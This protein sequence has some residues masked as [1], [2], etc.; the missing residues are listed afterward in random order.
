MINRLRW[1]KFHG[2]NF[3]GDGGTGG[4]GAAGGSGSGSAGGTP[5]P[6]GATG[7]AGAGTGGSGAAPSGGA[8]PQ[9]DW[10]TAPQ[11]LRDAFNTTKRTLEELQAKYQP[12]DK[13][14]VRPEDV[15]N[16]QGGYQ[17][18]YSEIKGI[19]DSLGISEQEVADAIR[20]HGLVRVLDHLR[21]EAYDADQV[22]NGNQ[23]AINDR[24]LQDRIESMVEQRLSPIQQRE[25]MRLVH[26]ANS[27]T[28]RTIHDL[29]VSNFKALGMDYAQAPAALRD[30]ITTGVT[31]V[32][33]YDDDALVALKMEG[34]TA[35]IQKAFQTFQSM[36]D[37][38][39][40]ARRAMETGARP[41]PGAAPGRPA[42]GNQPPGKA[43]S[44]DE[45]IDNPDRIRELGGRPAYSS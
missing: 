7:G 41:A 15:Q 44:I 13:L 10:N 36:W 38:A 43:K 22:A 5:P 26:E 19:G 28:E 20:Q 6:S 31:E 39:Y 4:G 42:Q 2:V 14:G 24:D 3:D 35:G 33:K 11:Q 17:Q 18:V 21:Q 25:N 23:D 32:L 29:A 16:F 12:W 8:A 30:F 9:I 45:L 37:A 1:T 40:L 34:K 27:L